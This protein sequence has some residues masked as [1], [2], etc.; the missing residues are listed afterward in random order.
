[1]STT[2]RRDFLRG[3]STLAIAGCA[4]SIS[5]PPGPIAELCA[6]TGRYK[7]AWVYQESERIV[8]YFGATRLDE[9]RRVLPASFAMPERPLV[10]VSVIDFYEMINGATYLESVISVL[11][12]HEGQPGFYI[13]TMPVTD[14]DSCWGGRV[15]F[16]YPKLVR[17]IT[18]E[19]RVNRWVGVSYAPGGREPEFTLALG[20]TPGEAAYDVLRL[21]APMPS[22]T[23][24]GGGVLRFGSFTSGRPAYELE[25]WAPTV[26]KVWLGQPSL[27]FP[28]EPDHL[29]HR[30]G[31]GQ[32]LAGYFA[33]VRWRSSITPG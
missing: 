28:R 17:R 7:G 22:F 12:L 4:P 31:V 25:R 16:G 29:L 15:S 21:V 23:L 33:R 20:G 19:R 30:L 13:V 2:S 18:L 14:G 8:A 10:F 26:W 5:G 32:P 3:L 24:Y 11:G 27:E 1:M 6:G 9:Y